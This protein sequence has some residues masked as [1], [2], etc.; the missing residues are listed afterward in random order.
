MN[1]DDVYDSKWNDVIDSHLEINDIEIC[2]ML[3]SICKV[4]FG[5][6]F[7]IYIGP[8]E[9]GFGWNPQISTAEND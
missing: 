6:M 7:G 1:P 8:F 9:I 4:K 3:L 2:G 5:F